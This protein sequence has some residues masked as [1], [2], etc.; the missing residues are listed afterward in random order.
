MAWPTKIKSI[1]ISKSEVQ[2]DSNLIHS[3]SDF[4]RLEK[5]EIKYGYAGLK[6]RN[7]FPYLN[8]SRRHG[9]LFK[10]QGI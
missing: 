5:F 10:I 3:K 8:F 7:N 2:T 6:I 9:I 1:K 4:P